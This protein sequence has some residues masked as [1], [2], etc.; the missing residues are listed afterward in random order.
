MA[1][2]RPTIGVMEGHAFPMAHF[3]CS[4]ATCASVR[5]ENSGWDSTR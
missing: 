2:P 5:S 4:L 1:F 3:S